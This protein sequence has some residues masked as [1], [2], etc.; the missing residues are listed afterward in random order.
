MKII[1][2]VLQLILILIVAFVVIVFFNPFVGLII[3][4]NEMEIATAQDE[5]PI[6]RAKWTEQDLEHY[7]F[8]I[9]ATNHVCFT[10]ARVEV[11]NEKVVQVNLKDDVTGDVLSR[12][13]SPSLWTNE[14]FPIDAFSCH[15]S[16]LTMTYLFDKAEQYLNIS[17]SRCL[18]KVS[19]DRKYGFVSRARLENPPYGRTAHYNFDGCFSG[20]RVENFQVLEK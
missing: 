18:I 8:E 2:M 15:Y 17:D 7:S 14:N 19:F 4:Y 1:K 3:K 16:P 10:N 5:L 20:F 11:R 13:L 6:A 12:A 9:W